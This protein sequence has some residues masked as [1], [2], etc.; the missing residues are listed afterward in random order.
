MNEKFSREA[1]HRLI[2]EYDEQA[3]AYVGYW[4]PFL[5][6]MTEA[7]VAS[8]PGADPPCVLDIGAGAGSMLPLLQDRFPSAR[9]IG[10]DRSEGMLLQAGDGNAL[11]VGD[12]LGLGVCDAVVDLALMNF[13]LFHLP[14][15][16]AGLREAHRV[17]RPGGMLSASTWATDMEAP[18][19]HIWNDTL[20]ACGAVPQE[21]VKRLAQHELMDTADKVSA[22]FTEAGFESVQADVHE[23][24]IEMAPDDFNTLRQTVGS[25]KHRFLSLDQKGRERCL[26]DVKRRFSQLCP[27]DFI[28]RVEVIFTTGRRLG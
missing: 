14:D 27:E 5:Q 13:M 12:A 18:P 24:G 23:F 25:S 7:F 6:P 10:L 4:A 2:T 26:A 8:L 11:A 16:V 9:V 15:P 28:F 1:V 20:D 21:E 22:L 3:P 17:L 19:V